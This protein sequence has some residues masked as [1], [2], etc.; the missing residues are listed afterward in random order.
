[1]ETFSALLVIYAG[2]SPVPGEF[3]TQR[4]VT[5]SFDVYFDLRPNKWLSKQSWGWWFETL[6]CSL[7]RHRNELHTFCGSTCNNHHEYVRQNYHFPCTNGWN[8]TKMINIPLW[9]RDIITTPPYEKKRPKPVT[10][11]HLLAYFVM[12]TKWIRSGMF[13]MLKYLLALCSFPHNSSH[14][15]AA[16]LSTNHRWFENKTMILILNYTSQ[17]QFLPRADASVAR[18]LDPDQAHLL[19]DS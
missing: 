13:S 7:W 8:I 18:Y 10:H 3:P 12:C 16:L 11:C 1:M 6:S 15:L 9:W 2:N 14:W 19:L 17:R 4:P 5:R